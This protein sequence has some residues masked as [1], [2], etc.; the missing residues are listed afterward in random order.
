VRVS[1]WIELARMTAENCKLEGDSKTA[2]FLNGI[3]GYL[4]Q[5]INAGIVDPYEDVSTLLTRMLVSR[6]LVSAY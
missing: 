3:A 4:E 2:Y 6:E 5:A 1:V